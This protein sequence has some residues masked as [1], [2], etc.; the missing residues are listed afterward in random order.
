MARSRL[1]AELPP[2]LQLLSA[3]VV[4]SFGP[5]LSQA[6]E[7]ARWSFELDAVPPVAPSGAAWREAVADLLAA[8]SLVWRDTDKKGRPRERECRP[9]LLA[10]CL[11]GAASAGDGPFSRVELALEAGVDGA[12]R[13]L[14]PDQLAHW[15]GTALGL[16]LRCGRQCRSA[17]LLRQENQAS[18][19][20]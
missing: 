4:P 12:G 3:A 17:L 11:S 5:S 8:N 1:Q 19:S 18:P 2:G 9:A 14:R 7:A 15:L 20:W 10:L 6:V 13:S 16:P